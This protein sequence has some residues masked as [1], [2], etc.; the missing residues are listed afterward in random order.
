MQRMRCRVVHATIMDSVIW[1]GWSS[2]REWHSRRAKCDEG[3]SFSISLFILTM[4][5]KETSRALYT[6]MLF[7]R[8]FVIFFIISIVLCISDA[9]RPSWCKTVEQKKKRAFHQSQINKM[10]RYKPWKELHKFKKV[11][12]EGKKLPFIK[13]HREGALI[14]S[15]V[16]TST[17]WLQISGNFLFVFIHLS[18]PLTH[19]APSLSC[20]QLSLTH[21]QAV[22]KQKRSKGVDAHT[23]TATHTHTN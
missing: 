2:I 19:S 3:R 14:F 5:E 16:A 6:S 7:H 21:P 20:L 23:Y 9:D 15:R 17:L 8:L 22:W 18:C 13:E 11:E 10:N 12:E 4:T 1:N